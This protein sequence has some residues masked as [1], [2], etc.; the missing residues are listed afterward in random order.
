[1]KKSKDPIA[2]TI[3]CG[4]GSIRAIL[5]DA[6]GNQ[7]AMTKKKFSAYYSQ[8]FNWKEAPAKMFWDGLVEVVQEIKKENP[9]DFSGIE[10]MTIACQRDTIS[11]VDEN[12][13]ALRDFIIWMDRREIDKPLP[14]PWPYRLLFKLIHFT[15]YAN[16]FSTTNHAHWI[17]INEPDIWQ[18]ADKLVFLSTYLIG[19]L[20]GKIIESRS[21]MAGHVPFDTKRKE[22]CHPYDVKAVLLQVEAEKRVDLIDSTEVF[23]P[24]TKTAAKQ[25]GLP[26]TCKVIASGT[27][28]GCESLGIGG[29][30][31]DIA[32][33]SLGTQVTL[34]VTT[35]KYVELYPF[36]PSFPA[37]EKESYNPE[38]TIY[39]GFWLIDWYIKAFLSDK[40][41]EEVYSLLD[42]YLKETS[43]GADGLVHQPYWGREA[44]RPAAKG[45]LI[46]LMEGHDKR[47]IYRSFIEGL[48]YGVLEGIERIEKKTKV[49]IKKIGLSGGGARSDQVAQIMADVFN[50]PV[51]RVQTE[52]T[53]GL[54]AAMAVFVGIG[55]YS[56]LEEARQEMVR[57]SVMFYP[58]A[59]NHQIYAKIYQGLYKKIYKRVKPLYTNFKL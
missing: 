34:E 49:T 42:D 57:E 27:D 13:L 35:K 8:Q 16:S 4:T 58:D 39:H 9:Q 37:V 54:G 50:R 47:H 33:V 36:Y 44:F 25:L 2:L 7:L 23:G 43:P 22:W 48:A 15:D 41:P 19:Q 46:G 26:E 28:K 12:G 59:K 29:M 31:P 18:E 32:S 17:K 11:L 6:W 5:F 30:T 52:E 24:L 45:S 40:N 3:D 53:T 55:R 14:Y 20:T 1:M 51:Y 10:G 21:S 56:S 38:V